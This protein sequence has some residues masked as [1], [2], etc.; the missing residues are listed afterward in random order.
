MSVLELNTRD[1]VTGLLNRESF[2]LQLNNW[3]E[4]REVNTRYSVIQV[5]LTPHAYDADN[6]TVQALRLYRAASLLEQLF[7]TQCLIARTRANSL[8]L[9]H[10]SN[11][12]RT[13]HIVSRIKSCLGS[14]G[15]LLD[16]PDQ[17]HIKTLT[18][19]CGSLNATQIVARL[20]R[21]IRTQASARSRAIRTSSGGCVDTILAR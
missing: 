11:G 16:M 17:L 6:S 21:P 12:P 8:V 14:L 4:A 13:R 3:M 9:G 5:T 1:S 18:L 2:I 15:G 10:P 20:E 19:S 7:A